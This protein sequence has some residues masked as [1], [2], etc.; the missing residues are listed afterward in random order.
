MLSYP[1]EETPTSTKAIKSSPPHST[2]NHHDRSPSQDIR[3]SNTDP[4]AVQLF[5]CGI[6][7]RMIAKQRLDYDQT[8]IRTK[9][10]TRT[11]PNAQSSNDFLHL[12]T[13]DNTELVRNLSGNLSDVKSVEDISLLARP[14]A[15]K[16]SSQPKKNT[17]RN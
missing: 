16:I 14:V 11:A 2:R 9:Y 1:Q 17:P 4:V 6:E 8:N 10:T 5:Q 7:E 15:K 13:L 12:E 3:K